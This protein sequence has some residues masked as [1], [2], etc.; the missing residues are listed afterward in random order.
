MPFGLS[1]IPSAFQRFMN[2]VFLDLLDIC[3]VIYLDNIL[4]Y[5]DNLEDHKK[6]IKEVLKRLQDNSLYAFSVKYTFCQRQ[7]EFLG[8]ILSP[9]KVHIDTKK[10]Q[11]IQD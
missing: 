3:V 5:S 1:N 9:E 6:H 2:K 8:F 7:V 10:V 4:I 11:I